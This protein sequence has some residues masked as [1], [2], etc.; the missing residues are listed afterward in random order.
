MEWLNFR[1]LYSFW[2][3]AKTGGFSLASREMNVAQ[4]AISD[5]VSQLEDYLEQELFNRTTRKVSLT[6]AGTALFNYAEKI[7]EQ[8]REINSVLRDKARPTDFRQLNLGIVGGA[9][10]NYV[11]RK[12]EDILIDRPQMNIHVTSGSYEDL[13]SQLTQFKLDLIIS[14]ELPG[15]KDLF[16][17]SYRKIGHT[18]MCMAG[19]KRLI[20]SIQK[21]TRKSEVDVFKF[22]HPYEVSILEDYVSPQIKI[23]YNLRL[24]TDDVPL[25]RFFANSKDGLV[26]I[27]RVGIMED[28]EAGKVGVLD[29][30]NCPEVNIYGIFLKAGIHQEL[31]EDLLEEFQNE[32]S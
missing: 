13:Y 1:H 12:V 18:K 19:D 2:M 30:K 7:F 15:K 11:F 4:S 27:P 16:E 24:T 10:R 20:S 29:I 31:I 6:D 9:S 23:P 25:L 22:S 26:V 32:T 28:L 14:L 8:S 17:L 5:Q 21:K 3:V